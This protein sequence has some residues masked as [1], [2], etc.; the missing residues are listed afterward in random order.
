MGIEI[1][2]LFYHADSRFDVADSGYFRRGLW[3]FLPFV[4]MV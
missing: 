4:C 2:A 3:G 1:E